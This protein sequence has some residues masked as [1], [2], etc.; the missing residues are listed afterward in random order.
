MGVGIATENNMDLNQIK[1][2]TRLVVRG[3]LK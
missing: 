2:D 1:E 3:L